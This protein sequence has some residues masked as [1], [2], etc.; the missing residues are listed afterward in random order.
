MAL[1][2]ADWPRS[3][4]ILQ[5]YHPRKCLWVRYAQSGASGARLGAAFSRRNG[6]VLQSEAL[7]RARQDDSRAR[8]AES[9]VCHGLAQRL[10]EA[11]S[12]WPRRRR[13]VDLYARTAAGWANASDCPRARS[14]ST[15]AHLTFARQIVLGAGAFRHGAEDAP[16]H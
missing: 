14:Y 15:H 6:L 5:L 4:R 2:D 1:A 13:N 7:W 12:G 10:A 9:S 3:Q 8:R 16:H 11:K